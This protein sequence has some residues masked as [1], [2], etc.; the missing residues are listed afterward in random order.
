MTALLLAVPL[1]L[2]KVSVA[3]ERRPLAI[4]G[5][6]AVDVLLCGLIPAFTG[7]AVGRPSAGGSC[8]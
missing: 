2:L 4:G 1:A 5:L 8:S 7:W 6:M 3:P